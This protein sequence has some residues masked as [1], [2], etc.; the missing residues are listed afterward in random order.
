MLYLASHDLL[1]GSR[2]NGGYYDYFGY[3]GP[4][5]KYYD[6]AGYFEDTH[7]LFVAGT[8]QTKMNDY[9]K[10]DDNCG[11]HYKDANGCV[12]KNTISDGEV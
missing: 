3:Y 4:G 11:D 6:G 2:L 8:V 9:E 12:D 10:N 7:I 5:W 1:G